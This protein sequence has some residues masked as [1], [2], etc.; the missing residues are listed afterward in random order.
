MNYIVDNDLKNNW[1]RSVKEKCERKVWKRSLKKK[2][3]REVWKR[4]DFCDM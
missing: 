4:R 2:C 1:K 3:E